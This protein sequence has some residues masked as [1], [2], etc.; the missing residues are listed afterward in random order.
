[1][2]EATGKQ[3]T[4]NNGEPLWSDLP[5]T[6]PQIAACRARLQEEIYLVDPILIVTL[7]A[8]A[9]EAVMGTT[10]AIT[11]NRGTVQNVKIPGRT[12]S[13][14]L[15]DKKG[16]WL[17]K[18]RGTWTM[19]T[20]RTEVTYLL[21]PTLHPAYVLR[22]G[23]DNSRDSPIQ[24]LIEDLRT[25][26]KIYERYMIESFGVVPDEAASDITVTDEVLNG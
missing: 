23:E 14:V 24:Q 20:E 10:F 15:T 16:A 18:V 5:P 4:R 6:A 3:R 22:R 8:I 11:K 1:M 26:T 13:A 21:L 9:T 25:A 2:N 7:G 12:Q 17:R 19:P